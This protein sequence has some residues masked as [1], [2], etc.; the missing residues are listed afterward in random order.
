MKRLIGGGGTG[1]PGPAGTVSAAGSGTAALPGIAF[2]ADL[3]TGIYNPA[4]DN[5]AI[6]TG[7]TGRLFITSAGLVGIGASAPGVLLDVGAN[8][9][10]IIRASNTNP[11]LSQDVLIGGYEFH[12]A[13]ASGSGAGVVGAVRMRSAD[14]VGS[15]AYMTFSTALGGTANDAERVRITGAGFVG[16]GTTTPDAL[17]TV[18]GIGAFGAGAVGTPSISATGDLNTGFW[19]PA[20]DTIAASTAGSERARIDSSGRLLVGT[21][22]A[23]SNFFNTTLTSLFQ[24]EGANDSNKRVASIVY[25]NSGDDGPILALGKTGSNSLGGNTL[26]V[27]GDQCGYITFQGADGTELVEAASIF[28]QVDGT[29]GA[30]DMPGRLVFSTTADGAATPTERLRI[31]STGQVR[32]AG[33]G[34][35]FNGDTAAANELDD[36]EEGTW[37][38]VYTGLT[39]SIGATAYTQQAGTYTK[40]G[41]QVTAT[42]RVTLSS[43]GSWT[44]TVVFT[45]LPFTAANNLQQ[46]MGSIWTDLVTFVDQINARVGPNEATIVPRILTSATNG[47]YLQTSGVADTSV[48]YATVTYFI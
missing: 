25:G 19:F 7:G 9:T 14:S 30:N 44:G 12:K 1:T 4:A 22:S 31:T 34:I 10:A 39:G 42:M 40:I 26:V 23:R 15:S 46:N 6:S 24:V 38:P 33:A 47:A 37:T 2:A 16:I 20:A 13:D 21:S 45:G 8:G 11:G 41:R 36:Y 27:N 32:L 5:L 28:A 29:P 18:N 35:T 43:K 17:L 3:N 48:F